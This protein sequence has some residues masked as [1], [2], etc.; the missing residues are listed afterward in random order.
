[1]INIRRS[2]ASHLD[3]VRRANRAVSLEIGSVVSFLVGLVVAVVDVL[4]LATAFMSSLVPED[5]E[6][7]LG[8]ML[9][10]KLAPSPLLIMLSALGM[11]IP[12]AVLI[13]AGMV[14]RRF[15]VRN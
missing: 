9:F 6:P 1:M 8:T 5:A 12:A 15:F 2:V 10:P 13:F 7:S 4:F 14:M 11:L 3:D